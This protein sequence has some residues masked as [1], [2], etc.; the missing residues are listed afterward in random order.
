MHT[1]TYMKPVNKREFWKDRIEKAKNGREHYSVFI[2]SEPMWMDINRK[3]REILD[4]EIK[5]T[6]NVID[7]GCAYGRSSEMVK[8]QYTGIDFSPDFIEI[9]RKKYPDK[10]FVLGSL[11]KLPFEDKEFD[12][13]FM[14]SVK[15]MIISNLGNKEWDIM[16]KECERVCK[17]LLIL[18]Y[19]QGDSG[20]KNNA[21][22]Y[23]II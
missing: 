13:G 16:Q 14:V 10:R 21:D 18:E 19:G 4:K 23:E 17:K 11:K 12:V 3:H 20:I 5:E 15:A 2:S 9:A 6:D 7:L 1:Y 22:E 8:G